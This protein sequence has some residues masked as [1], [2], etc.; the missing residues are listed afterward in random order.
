MDRSRTPSGLFPSGPLRP[1][2]REPHPVRVGAVLA[3]AG[4]TA[5][6][7]LV[8]A[9]LATSPRSFVWLVLGAAIL[10]WLVAVLLT[11]VG[12]RGVA[13]GVALSAGAGVAIAIGLVVARWVTTGWFLW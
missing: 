10:A 12:D 5:G 8:S 11:F 9:L 3:G 7:L 4:A 13:V 6:W 1:A 2:F